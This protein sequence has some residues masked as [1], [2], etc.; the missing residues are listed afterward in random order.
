MIDDTHSASD[1]FS[2]V[3]S[4]VTLSDF[5]QTLP[6]LSSLSSTGKGVWR[7]NNVISGGSNP[8][9][10]VID[11][12]RGFFKVFSHDQQ[13]GDVITLYSM[14]MGSPDVAP[15]DNALALASH[16]GVTVDESLK[17]KNPHAV[18]S[19]AIM[20][21]L[22]TI[23]DAAHHYLMFSS[24]EDASVAREYL[25]SCG[26]DDDMISE[27]N[28]GLFPSQ[29]SDMHT[30]ISGIRDD[31]LRSSGLVSRNNFSFIPMQGRLVF[32]ILSPHG[33]TLSFSSR[34]IDGIPTPLEDSKYIN[35]LTTDV[36]DKSRTLYGQHRITQSTQRIVICEGN[37][38]VLALNRMVDD[39]TVAVAT[40]GTALT[41]GH[42]SALSKK[43]I[44]P[45]LQF[46]LMVTML[47][48]MQWQKHY[49][50]TTIM[51][52]SWR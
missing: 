38:D 48:V 15:F 14:T 32:P 49:G 47:V 7:C 27:W 3:K 26:M 36:Y 37:F 46:Y 25:H 39:N 31:I 24:H 23:A 35:T 6:S 10:M 13:Y 30:I 5:V 12:N 43:K 11:D 19:S 41:I 1:I 18:S 16:M 20:S 44:S 17:H 22:D 33:K 29:K 2:F 4:H 34:V 45:L 21:A 42:I 28:L 51:M 8:T 50:C 40:C 9:A 52:M